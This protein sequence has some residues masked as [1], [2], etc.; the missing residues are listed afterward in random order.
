MPFEVKAQQVPHFK[1]HFNAK[2]KTSTDVIKKQ[3]LSVEDGN[4]LVSLEA[5]ETW[6]KKTFNNLYL[7]YFCFPEESSYITFCV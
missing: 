7:H 1:A 3:V 5:V 2:K 6:K 4:T